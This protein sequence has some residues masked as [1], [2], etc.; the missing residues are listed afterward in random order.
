MGLIRA[1]ATMAWKRQIVHFTV[2]TFACVFLLLGCQSDDAEEKYLEQMWAWWTLEHAAWE[3]NEKL[4]LMRVLFDIGSCSNDA[5][6]CDAWEVPRAYPSWRDRH[7]TLAGSYRIFNLASMNLARLEDIERKRLSARG[8]DYVSPSCDDM[9]GY[10]DVSTG[11]RAACN[12]YRV[13]RT[14]LSVLGSKW[15]VVYLWDGLDR[16]GYLNPNGERLK[17]YKAR[18]KLIDG[19]MTIEQDAAALVGRLAEIAASTRR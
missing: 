10:A 19:G 2:L 7:E 18:S 11:Y 8:G 15:R 4:A 9:I 1:A 17:L 3:P 16:G 13:S 6:T 12:S 14:A 5:S